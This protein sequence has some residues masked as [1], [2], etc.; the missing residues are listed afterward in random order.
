VPSLKAGVARRERSVI[1]DSRQQT[2]LGYNAID[3]LTSLSDPKNNTTHWIYD[4]QGRL[5]AKQYADNSTVTY[6]YENTTSRL[7]SATDA[8]GQA[9][10]FN[11]TQDNRLAGISYA[12]AVHPTPNVSFAYDPYFPRSV[13]MTDGN[14]TTH[15]SYVGGFSFGAL[16][17]QQECFVPTGAST[18]SYQINY[19]YDGLGRT[20]S[21]TVGGAGAETF[22]YDAIGRLTGHTNDLGSFAL[23]YLGQTA[24]I[25]Q[26][27]LLPVS[28]NMATSWSYL[29]NAGD[30]R[31]A[32]INNVGLS[33]SQFSNYQFTTTPENFISAITEISDSTI[34]FPSPS[35]Q[36]ASYNNL[37]QLA[38]LSG[39]A[40]SYDANGNLLADGQ[41]NYTWDA[42]NRLVG[43]TYPGQ[44][45]KQTAFTYDGRGRRTA[46]GSTPVGGSTITT[47]YIWCGTRI[48]QARNASNSPTR[49]YFAEGE[50]V[51]GTAAQP[52]Y[53]GVDQLGSVRRAFASPGSAPAYSYDPYGNRLQATAP[54]TDFGYAGMFNNVESGLYLTQY[55]AYDPVA[56][57]WLSRD[58]LGESSDPAANL[59]RYVQGN[60][61]RFVDLSGLITSVVINNNSSG[62]IS[63]FTGT[64][65]GVYISNNGSPIIYD[66]GGSYLYNQGRSSGGYVAG[67]QADLQAYLQYQLQS[68]P[69]LQVYT[70]NTTPEEEAAI[71]DR[72]Q[73]GS[74]PGPGF[75]ASGVSD[76]LN[77]IGPFGNL[78]HYW[79][80]SGLGGALRG[81]QRQ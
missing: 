32:G 16:Q 81:L 54:L 57:R 71:A 33:S 77:G 11:Y 74:D 34:A 24:Q 63:F 44:S 22:Q 20:N 41:R 15:Y 13:S 50:F 60:P 17:L 59:Y 23:A 1:R 2:L 62:P 46:I 28:S 72:I 64:H 66:P 36:T 56:G 48:C 19:A 7:K 5:T 27:Q 78:G 35:T 42:E 40:L 75:C 26:R 49:E 38:V 58:P 4:V 25:T 76:A 10:Q 14:G 52:Y 67:D 70:F 79:T 65:S 47:S 55:R 61:L 68:G 6:A 21:R 45:G 3:K 80:P 18:C 31:L 9:K 39:R 43:I 69:D 29:A 37:N 73:N 12:N 53:Y 30:R 8:L 51:P